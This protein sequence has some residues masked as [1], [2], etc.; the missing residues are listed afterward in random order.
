MSAENQNNDGIKTIIQL[1]AELKRL[2]EK[3]DSLKKETSAVWDQYEKVQARL[4]GLMAD[5]GMSSFKVKDIGNVV[6]VSK[7]RTSVTDKRELFEFLRNKGLGSLI[8]ESI[9]YRDRD[10]ENRAYHDEHGKDMPGLESYYQETVTI[11]KG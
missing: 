5:L 9:D 11:K 8:V 7:M 6:C 2:K 10:R 4:Y 1:S 3:H